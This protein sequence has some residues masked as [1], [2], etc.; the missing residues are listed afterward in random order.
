MLHNFVIIQAR[1]PKLG[2][3]AQGGHFSKGHSKPE[4]ARNYVIIQARVPKFGLRVPKG[5]IF[6]KVLK[7][8]SCS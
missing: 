7:A 6:V 2:L 1:V 4:V 5:V 8:G 3:R